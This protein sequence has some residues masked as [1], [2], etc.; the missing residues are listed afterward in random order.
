LSGIN[1]IDYINNTN[2]GLG[3]EGLRFNQSINNPTNTLVPDSIVNALLYM[4]DHIP[5]VMEIDVNYLTNSIQESTDLTDVTLSFGEAQ[6]KFILNQELTDFIFVLYSV[7]GQKIM[8]L[9]L[10]D[11]QQIAIVKS[12]TSGVYV[13]SIETNS[14][15]IKNKVIVK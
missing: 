15:L 13:W 7:N 11:I 1:G 2:R 4:S 5:I 10:T 8:E 14:R 9:N 3:K 12:L 6:N